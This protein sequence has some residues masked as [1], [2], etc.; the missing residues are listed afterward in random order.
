M[1]DG[2]GMLYYVSPRPAPQQS[3]SYPRL[4]SF[5]CANSISSLLRRAASSS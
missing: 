2:Y 1:V 4:D 3:P 5:S